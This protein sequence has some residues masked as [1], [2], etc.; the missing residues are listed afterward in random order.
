MS[1]ANKNLAVLA[2]ANGFT[3]WYYRATES[4]KDIE[5]DNNYFSPVADLMNQGDIIV[6]NCA[7]GASTRVIKQIENKQITLG[8]LQ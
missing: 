5:Q 1:F 7:E 3:L 4:I 8:E 2:C 6:F